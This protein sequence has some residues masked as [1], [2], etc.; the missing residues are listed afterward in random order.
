MEK[1]CSAE[2]K[3]KIVDYVKSRV[4]EGNLPTCR[5]LRTKFAFQ[6]GI[7]MEDIYSQLNVDFLK[8]PRHRS[9]QL[10]VHVRK[11]LLNYLKNEV[12]KGHYP[13][14]RFI[15]QKFKLRLD[16][17]FRSIKEFYLQAGIKYIQKNSQDLKGNKALIFTKLIADVLYKLDLSILEINDIHEQGVD[18]VALDTNERLIGVELKAFNKYEPIKK[19][20][21]E[22][23][24][25]FLK[26]GFHEIILMTTTSKIESKISGVSGISIKLYEDV[27]PLLSNDQI[28]KIQYI[29]DS[30]VHE[31]TDE[32]VR[33]KKLIVDYLKEN[34][35][36]GREVYVHDINKALKLD[37]RS[38]FKSVLDI[39]KE[40]NIIPP[41][42]KIGGR[43]NPKLDQ[44][45][46]RAAIENIL[47]YMKKE[48]SSG[49]Y[50]SGKDIRKEFGISHIWDYITMNDLYKLLHEP[51]YLERRKLGLQ[52]CR[53][54]PIM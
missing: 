54:N 14:R 36:K 44:C 21:V 2:I 42:N 11:D 29:R 33:K 5:E 23:L 35:I 28:E 19:K 4:K 41:L 25:Q 48:I 39:Y 34:L 32:K 37:T 46:F 18:M 30:S 43:R 13:S 52:S 20:N 26:Q 15:E 47:T 51:T 1:N 22:Q 45:L 49:H 3:R 6:K 50:P 10:N 9:K 53:G 7:Y 8:F 12:K 16:T 40:A 24:Q 27:L 31:E 38:Y 17:Y